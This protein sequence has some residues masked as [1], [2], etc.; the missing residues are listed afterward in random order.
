MGPSLAVFVDESGELRLSGAGRARDQ[1]GDV[2]RRRELDLVKDLP[3]GGAYA[4]DSVH[5]EATSVG[6]DVVRD[7][8]LARSYEETL[9]QGSQV[10][11]E[12]ASALH[13]GLGKRASC[14]AALHV[15][16]SDRRALEDWN[17]EHRFDA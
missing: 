17:A 15:E 9:D 14:A 8:A 6:R 10:A 3:H 7:F 2:E 4:D 11:R 13:F 5:L 16:D 12:R 1:D